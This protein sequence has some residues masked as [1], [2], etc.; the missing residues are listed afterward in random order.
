MDGVSYL[1]DHLPLSIDLAR[2]H[3]FASPPE[4]LRVADLDFHDERRLLGPGETMWYR[5]DHSGTYEFRLDH[6]DPNVYYEVYLGDD[7]SIP[8]PTYR[9][10]RHP[11]LG[12][13][14]VLVAPF[15]VKIGNR[16]RDRE[17]LFRF[18]SHRHSGID[19][20]DAIHLIPGVSYR[21]NLPAQQFN[22]DSF[23]SAWDDTDTKWFQVDTPRVPLPRLGVSVDLALTLGPGPLRLLVA[24]READGSA[25]LVDQA[26]PSAGSS[27][28]S[29]PARPDESFY[30]CVQRQD[31]AFA[32]VDFTIK[33]GID[34]SLV[35]GG[36]A[37]QPRLVCEEETSGWGADDISLRMKADGGWGATVSNDAIGDFE[38]DS[39]RYLDQWI[40]AVVPY[41]SGF[42]VT[43]VEEDDIDPDDVGSE[44]LP[45]FADLAAWP[46]WTLIHQDQTGRVYGAA[47]IDV[48]DGTYSFR[49]S[50]GRWDET[51]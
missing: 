3:P 49:C 44:T 24:R 38:Q 31:A 43:V 33:A 39:V 12:D 42:E 27:Q 21:E 34:V 23:V 20:Q 50:I 32:A 17:F 48:D 47:S 9:N 51:V 18:N 4:A 22:G 19:P 41:R 5:Y 30:V 13:R 16:R 11:D 15:V 25:T 36:A 35:R 8:R 37:G 7:L 29:W 46:R 45:G 1:S 6:D 10:E 2:P 28:L 14:F 26:A 40:P